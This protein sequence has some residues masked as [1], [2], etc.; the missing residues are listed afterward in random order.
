MYLLNILNKLTGEVR[1]SSTKEKQRDCPSRDSWLQ[2]GQWPVCRDM[3]LT[4][5]ENADYNLELIL[6]HKI[7]E[8]V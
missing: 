7:L 1:A 8:I 2:W 3:L 6:I 5:L 4:T